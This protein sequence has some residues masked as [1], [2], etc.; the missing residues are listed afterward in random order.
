[1]EVELALVL[2]DRESFDG[3]FG[4]GMRESAEG[5]FLVGSSIMQVSKLVR[6]YATDGGFVVS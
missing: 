2:F 3:R 5:D 4:F 6:A 1:V